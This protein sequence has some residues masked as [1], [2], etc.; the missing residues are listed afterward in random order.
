MA[1]LISCLEMEVD[2]E[3]IDLMADCETE[4]IDVA[5]EIQQ[6]MKR[7]KL[8]FD[9]RDGYDYLKVGCSII[10]YYAYDSFTNQ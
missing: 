4:D 8:A 5:D 7:E 9:S 10:H 6:P 3:V 1:T 2:G